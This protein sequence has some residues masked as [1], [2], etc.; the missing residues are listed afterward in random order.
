MPGADA[1]IKV[2]SE[3]GWEAVVVVIIMLSLLAFFGFLGK[4]F[5]TSMDKRLDEA[6]KRE[7]RLAARITT[8]ESFVENTLVKL[9]SECT[10]LLSQNITTIKALTDALG[11]K[12]CLLDPSRQNEVVD[13]MADRLSERAADAVRERN[14]VR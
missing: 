12:P 6:S 1:A 11:Q 5:I 3:R 13:R 10:S 9:V 7:E 8:L 2:A 4:W 14:P